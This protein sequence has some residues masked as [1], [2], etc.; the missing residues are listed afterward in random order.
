MGDVTD[1]SN[2]M[3]AVIDDRAFAKHK[4][5]IAR[6]KR[7]HELDVI[8]GG[9]VDDSNGYFVRPT[10]V[11]SSD[12]TDAMFKDESSARSSRCTSTTTAGFEQRR[13]PDGAFAP[14]ALTGAIFAQDRE[15]DRLGHA[16][17]CASPRATSTSTTSPPAPWS[18]SSR[19]AA[20]AP[21]AP[22][23][24]PGPAQPAALD[25]AALDQGDLRAAEGLPLPAHG[26][27]SLGG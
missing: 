19:S 15:A 11:E 7:S 3:G 14:Y 24:R 22:T 23:T 18:A 9:R 8:A 10:V 21:P 25:L 17:G 5:A 6:A 26:L 16:S 12:P 4:K 27:T 20:R 1:L 13:G 2:F